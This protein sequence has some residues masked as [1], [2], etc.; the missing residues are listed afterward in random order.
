MST[1]NN[2]LFSG[3]SRR[4]FLLGASAAALA[5]TRFAD[6]VISNIPQPSAV[7][8]S[9]VN[10]Q[11]LIW[12]NLLQL[13]SNMWNDWAPAGGSE[14]IY[15]SELYFDKKLWDDLLVKMAEVGMT[16]LVID[17][18]NGI[19]Y[20]SHPEISVKNAW[21]VSELRQELAK[22]RQMGL[23]PIPKLNFS[24]AHDAWLGE[25]SRCVSTDRYYGVCKELIA[26]VIELFDKPR[27]FHLGY[28]EEMA[29]AQEE[30]LYVVVRQYDLWW[31]DFYFFIDQVEQRRV[32]P[33][34]WSDYLWNHP[35]EFFKK[36]PKSV[37]QSNWHY[38]WPYEE[39]DKRVQAYVKLHEHGYDQIPTASNIGNPHNFKQTVTFCRKYIA[40]PHLLGFIQTPWK[41]T[42]EAHRQHHLAAIEQVGQVIAESTSKR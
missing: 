31:H 17:L 42:V 10:N 4:D 40:S 6:A 9:Q 39:N 14:S 25:Y 18:G 35:D 27:L 11:K 22:I 33:W 7:P 34:I 5:N 16:M 13:S 37:L 36:M 26:E 20:Q 30:Y 29:R 12:A 3:V 32:R 21:S 38:N 1:T 23:E 24:T 41:L 28:D 19:K 8:Q 15:R 2:R